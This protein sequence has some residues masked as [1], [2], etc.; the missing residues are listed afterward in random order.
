MERFA[1]IYGRWSGYHGNYTFQSLKTA[2][3]YIG[4]QWEGVP[5]RALTDALACHAL[6]RWMGERDAFNEGGLAAGHPRLQVT[7]RTT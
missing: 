2:V 4:Y 7:Q 6:W 3:S 1:P 5:H